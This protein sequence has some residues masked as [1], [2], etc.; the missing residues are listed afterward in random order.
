[1]SRELVSLDT[2]KITNPPGAKRFAY[3]MPA[4]ACVAF[5]VQADNAR[6]VTVACVV[7]NKQNFVWYFKPARVL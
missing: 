2:I 3:E 1:M 4:F 6:N 7:R 5:D